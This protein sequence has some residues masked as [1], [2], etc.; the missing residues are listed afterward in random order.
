M[1]ATGDVR[2]DGQDRSVFDVDRNDRFV[3]DVAVVGYGPVGALLAN[4]L[5][6]AGLSV[7]V[8]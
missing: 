1:S 7:V 4:L 8:F 6:Q 3:F 5:G 2:A